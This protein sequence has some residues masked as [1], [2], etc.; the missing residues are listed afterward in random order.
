MELTPE[1]QQILINYRTLNEARKQAIRASQG[2]FIYWLQNDLPQIWSKV[3]N[4]V[5]ELWSAF[6]GIFS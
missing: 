1:E 6:K 4:I 5:S 2:A 3:A